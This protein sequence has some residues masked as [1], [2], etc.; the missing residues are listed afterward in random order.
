MQYEE[1]LGLGGLRIVAL[2][3]VGILGYK[4][5]RYLV[6]EERRSWRILLG[7]QKPQEP[8]Q[9]ATNPWDV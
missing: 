9:K 5:F 8:S 3:V 7:R 2:V 4:M 6:A 1:L